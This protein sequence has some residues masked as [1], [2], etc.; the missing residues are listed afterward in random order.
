MTPEEQHIRKSRAKEYFSG[1]NIIFTNYKEI[2][3]NL[4]IT[5]IHFASDSFDEYGYNDH[6]GDI[7]YHYDFYI[8]KK[9]G[10]MNIIHIQ[11]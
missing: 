4:K 7:L 10:F 3:Q 8:N 11:I 6:N 1:D 9:V 5:Y 2:D